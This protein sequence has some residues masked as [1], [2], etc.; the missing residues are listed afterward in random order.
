MEIFYLV[1]Q[2]MAVMFLFMVVGY[3]LRKMKILPEGT[4]KVLSKLELFVFLPAMNFYNQLKNCTP[5]TFSENYRLIIMGGVLVVIG[6]ALAYPISRLIIRRGGDGED[7]SYKRNIYRYALAIANTGFFGN[8]LVLNIWGEKGLF[9]YTLFTFCITVV[10]YSW[11]LAILMPAGGKAKNGAKSLLK[12]V[13]TPALISLVLGATLGLVGT[14]QYVPSFI[15]TTLSGASE[16]MGPSAMI[17]S[18]FVIAG[19][20]LKRIACQRAV[21]VASLFRLIIIPGLFLTAL[22]LLS[23]D[24]ALPYAFV[25]FASPLGLNTIVVPAS[26]GKD[27]KTG[28]SMALISTAIS[29]LTLPLN[30]YI[31]FV[32]WA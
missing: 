11:G 14:Y 22:K 16:C 10:I 21:Y 15:L 32:L 4:D 1:L 23:L 5:E 6:V 31:F 25:A 20:D 13:C 28:A 27:T 7:L 9:E 24:F 30:Y 29:L 17:L 3:A 18:G 2:Q 26:Y 19:Y 8:F 12:R